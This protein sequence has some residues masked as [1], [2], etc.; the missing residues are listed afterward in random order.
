MFDKGD[1]DMIKSTVLGMKLIIYLVVAGAGLLY[2]V[3]HDINKKKITEM[4]ADTHIHPRAEGMKPAGL[5]PAGLKPV[6]R[7]PR[8]NFS[9]GTAALVIGVVFVVLA[10]LIFATTAWQTL[11]NYS[12]VIMILGF[13]GLFFGSSRMASKL[14]EIEKTS[15]AFYILGSV[16]LFLT[17][18]A[19]AYFGLLG[20]GFS[21]EEQHRFR[22]LCAGS[23]ATEL[24]LLAGIRQFKDK[25]YTQSCFWGL[26]V[27]MFFFLKALNLGTGDVIKGMACYSAVLVIAGEYTAEKRA[28]M[29]GYLNADVTLFAG[30][31]FW[32]FSALAAVLAAFEGLEIFVTHLFHRAATASLLTTTAVG[33]I[34]AGITIL[35]LRRRKENLQVVHGISMI[36]LFWYLGMSIPA[37]FIYQ[38]LAAAV[39]TGGWFFLGKRM[40]NALQNWL[41][42]CLYTPALMLYTAVIMLIAVG[43][44]NSVG[45]LLAAT[46]AVGLVTGVCYHWSGKYFAIR[47]LIPLVLCPVTITL[48]GVMDV[49]G[50]GVI[51]FPAAVLI[52]LLAVAVW[53]VVKHDCFVIAILVI[54][55]TA[56]LN[57]WDPEQGLTWF[58]VLLSGYLFIK[59]R[60]AEH[61]R[62]D[63]LEK[64]GCVYLLAGT[65][66][67]VNG[68]TEQV[69]FQMLC[70]TVVFA[71]E[72]IVFQVRRKSVSGQLFWEAAGIILLLSDLALFYMDA[73]LAAV[74]L[75]PC[76]IVFIVCYVMLYRYGSRWLHLLAA[77]SILPMPVA[78]AFRYAWTEHQLYGGTAA[79]VLVSI[80]LARCYLPIV[81]R[82][83]DKSGEWK[84][85]WLNVLVIM[86]LAP[87]TLA[88][89]DGWQCAYLI[90]IAVYVLQYTA[91][92]PLRRAA[93]TMA[94]ALAVLAC[95]TQP[96]VQI[97]DVLDLEVQLA[98][99]VLFAWFLGKVW[100]GRETLPVVRNILYCL[101]LGLLIIDALC[102]GHVV[103]ALIVEVVCLLVF[104]W[105]NTKKNVFWF[106][107]S[108][109][110][111][112]GI[113]LYMTKTFWLSLSW[114]VYLLAAGLGLI[115][116]AAVNEMKKR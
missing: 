116:F 65:F 8:A 114:W 98:P 43:N 112:V 21:L 100:T 23:L 61:E 45:E 48:T 14:F 60:R 63:L 1:A 57:F 85:D 47:P 2:K 4:T 24:A 55:S 76:L 26:S 79:A 69:L 15:R 95:W 44:W 53:D 28:A 75:I 80:F 36:A 111:I 20:H 107:I 82:E 68:L 70:V 102:G 41:T 81:S 29:P 22:V 108:G 93:L 66:F 103:D 89:G 64:G 71:A 96:F 19:A 18:L 90:L 3:L 56:Q 6:P 94:G 104:L 72:Y 62:K 73:S 83:E 46:A 110:V 16:F 12:K 109:T 115:A 54:G 59:S 92:E 9:Q 101:S 32:I 39:L 77:F 13:S 33:M 27:S 99:V 30:F 35:T 67:V 88:A 105:A 31:H 113:A 97:P 10:G 5:K 51:T 106:R 78:A 49:A 50:I 37:E 38:L 11:P 84:C 34:T 74:Y 17:V 52:F 7:K 25:I 86:L 40:N 91:V 58:A 42:D 87:M